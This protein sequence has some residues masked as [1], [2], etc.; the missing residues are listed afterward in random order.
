[1]NIV[2]ALETEV[3]HTRIPIYETQAKIDIDS[4]EAPIGIS[5]SLFAN[6][7]TLKMQLSQQIICNSLEF[8]RFGREHAI[9]SMFR[10]LYGDLH[11][12][13]DVLQSALFAR[14]YSDAMAQIGVIKGLLTYKGQK[15]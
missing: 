9:E 5:S 6:I 14:E 7:Y 10:T 2:D 1:M 11:R 4:V 3:D 12:E 8:E 15:K 13:L